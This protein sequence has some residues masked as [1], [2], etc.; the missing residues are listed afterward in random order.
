MKERYEVLK[1]ARIFSHYTVEAFAIKTN[2]SVGYIQ[3]LEAGEINNLEYIY[4]KYADAL[5]IP[6]GRIKKVI[7]EAEKGRWE[8]CKIADEVNRMLQII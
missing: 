7:S 3:K 2:L 4:S 1:Q 6:I 5:R 8:K